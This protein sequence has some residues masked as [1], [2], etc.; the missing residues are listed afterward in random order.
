VAL[1]GLAPGLIRKSDA[2]AVRL[3]LEGAH[4]VEEAAKE[5]A[6][7]LDAVGQHAQAFIVQRMAPP[8]V[9]MLVGVARTATS[10]RLSPSARRAGPSSYSRM[11]RSG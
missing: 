7:H 6:K 10:D 11:R 3:D 5:I 1:K 8:G 2:G 9:E 4:A